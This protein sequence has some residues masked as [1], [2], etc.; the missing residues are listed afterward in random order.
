MN[1]KVI[2][3]VYHFKDDKRWDKQDIVEG[4]IV[5]QDVYRIPKR[6]KLTELIDTFNFLSNE[7]PLIP[8]KIEFYEFSLVNESYE[9]FITNNV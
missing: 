4:D 6:T 8:E 1:N 3:T 2:R 9:H 7:P 5:P